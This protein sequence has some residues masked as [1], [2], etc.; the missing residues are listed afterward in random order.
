MSK[1][2]PGQSPPPE[3]GSRSPSVAVRA[4]HVALLDLSEETHH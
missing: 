3:G 4:D 2:L 1:V